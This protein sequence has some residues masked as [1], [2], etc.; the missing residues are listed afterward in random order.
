[1]GT[2]DRHRPALPAALPE[3]RLRASRGPR[4]AVRLAGEARCACGRTL[5]VVAAPLS[6]CTLRRACGDA[7]SRPPGSRAR[8]WPAPIILAAYDEHARPGE[9]RGVEPGGAVL[10]GKIPSAKRPNAKEGS[11]LRRE[12][13]KQSH[14]GVCE[15]R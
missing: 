13:P 3:S 1:L 4:G 2:V 9:A 15:V 12:G 10:E 11:D 7:P 6:R 14:P 5:P 8:S